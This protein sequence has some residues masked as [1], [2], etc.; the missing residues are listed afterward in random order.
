MAILTPENV[1]FLSPVGFQL[2]L[3][4]APEMTYYL[5][6]TRIPS[7]SLIDVDGIETPFVKMPVPGTK[8]E[9]EGVN[10]TFMVDEDMKNY[11]EL[12]NW[13]VSLGF[14]ESFDQATGWSPP[15]PGGD[16]GY[17]T[18]GTLTILTSAMTPNITVTYRDMIIS[19]LS[20]IE[21]DSK[22]SDIDHATCTVTF[23]IRGYVIS[24][25]S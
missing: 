23:K 2:R 17:L 16:D 21:F 13:M 18:D 3:S 25:L 6:A 19:Q 8:L 14:P 22:V 24:Q 12:F 20:D 10:F 5:T 7:V 9:F 1:N 15:T 11:L 4:R